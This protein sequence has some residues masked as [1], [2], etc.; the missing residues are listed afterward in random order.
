MD[1]NLKLIQVA[2]QKNCE[3][4]TK[5]GHKSDGVYTIVSLKSDSEDIVKYFVNTVHY[6]I[7]QLALNPVFSSNQGGI[8]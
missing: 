2:F 5:E 4:I 3:L 7:N 1:I 8:K 6:L